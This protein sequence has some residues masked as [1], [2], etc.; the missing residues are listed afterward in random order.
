[1]LSADHQYRTS[2]QRLVQWHIRTVQNLGNILLSRVGRLVSRYADTSRTTPVILMIWVC[3][4]N[5]QDFSSYGMS[6]PLNSFSVLLNSLFP[7]NTG[8]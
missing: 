4:W 8:S 6:E 7:G 5:G 2:Q 1:M 3:S